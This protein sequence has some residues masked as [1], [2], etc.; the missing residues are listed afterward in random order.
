[1]SEKKFNKVKDELSKIKTD[2]LKLDSK[3]LWKL[4][5]TLCPESQDA[6]CAM[7]DS[8]ANL[9]T[10]DKALTKRGLEVFADR[11]N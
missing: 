11:L 2:K 5:K 1:M 3:Q 9:I 8:E 10:S 7:N 6:P 4:K